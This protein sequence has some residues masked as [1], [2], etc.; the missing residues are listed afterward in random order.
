V[1]WLAD[2]AVASVRCGRGHRR[3]QHVDDLDYPGSGSDSYVLPIKRAVRKAEALE[4]A[5]LE[6]P[7]AL[8]HC[9]ASDDLF[10]GCG[11]ARGLMPRR[12]K[13]SMFCRA[14]SATRPY[15]WSAA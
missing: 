3:R 15:P 1:T 14:T 4:I 5:R 13:A 9:A 6:P 12:A 2:R 10:H 8:S 11:T 7:A